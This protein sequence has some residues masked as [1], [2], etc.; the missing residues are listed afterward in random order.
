MTMDTTKS[1]VQVLRDTAERIR[2]SANYAILTEN[3]EVMRLR[4]VCPHCGY[5]I[6]NPV[7]LQSLVIL[8]TRP[9]QLHKHYCPRCKETLYVGVTEDERKRTRLVIRGS[10]E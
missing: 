1:I 3:D 5:E 6:E 4:G 10:D 7:S 2:R 8:A 9:N